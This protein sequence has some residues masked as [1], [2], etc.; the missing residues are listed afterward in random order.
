MNVAMN[1]IFAITKNDYRRLQD[2]AYRAQKK[3]QME[4]CGVLVGRGKEISL[5]FVENHSNT[6]GS[7]VI[8]LAD[9]KEIRSKLL[10]RKRVM[11][12]FHSHIV[13]KPVPSIRDIKEAPIHSLMLIYD[14]CGREAALYR[15]TGTRARKSVSPR[16][17][18]I[19]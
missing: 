15:V 9:V 8:D 19:R 17:L 10:G 18:Y 7:F 12:Y 13:S 6:S 5:Q 3:N 2:R 16:D 4:V 11:G 14:V 1:S